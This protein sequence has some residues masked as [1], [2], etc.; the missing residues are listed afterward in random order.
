MTARWPPPQTPRPGVAAPAQPSGLRLHSHPRE[1]S[2]QDVTYAPRHERPITW[3]ICREPRHLRPHGSNSLESHVRRATTLSSSNH[4]YLAVSGEHGRRRHSQRCAGR[5][6]LRRDTSDRAVVDRFGEAQGRANQ[7]SSRCRTSSLRAPSLSP[8]PSAPTPSPTTSATDAEFAGTISPAVCSG[9]RVRRR[10]RSRLRK[11]RTIAA[12][13][14]TALR[15]R[16]AGHAINRRREVTCLLAQVGL[17]CFVVGL[18]D[19]IGLAGAL[20]AQR[21]QQPGQPLADIGKI[22]RRAV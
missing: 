4:R 13:W 12:R 10:P 16:P 14:P 15:H 22:H 6:R 2:S 21:G 17:K 5:G 11:R 1:P 19:E 18:V 9:M 20:V 7:V 8:A 3:D